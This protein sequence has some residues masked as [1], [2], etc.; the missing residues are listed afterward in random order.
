[1]QYGI[2]L[3]K[4]YP[5]IYKQFMDYCNNREIKFKPVTVYPKDTQSGQ[6][7]MCIIMLEADNESLRQVQTVG[8]RI[9]TVDVL[10]YPLSTD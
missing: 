8:V 9:R 1:M 7:F 2:L 10:N 5:D 6:S 4:Q 3:R